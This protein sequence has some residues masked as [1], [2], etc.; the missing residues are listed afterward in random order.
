MTRKSTWFSVVL[1][2]G[3]LAVLLIALGAAREPAQADPDGEARVCPA[4]PPTCDFGTIQEAV[5]AAAPGD[6]IKVADGT[7]TDMHT[8]PIP[9]NYYAPPASGIITQI[10]YVTK[11]LTIRG[12]YAPGNWVTSDPDAYLTVLDAQGQGRAV[13]VADDVSVTLES[14]T[15][16]GGDALGLSGDV[17]GDAG[18]ALFARGPA[19]WQHLE[20]SVVRC[21]V[22]DNQADTGG[23]IYAGSADGITILNSE[24]ISN[25]STDWGGGLYM[26]SV[27]ES[28][29]GNNRIQNNSAARSGGGLVLNWVYDASLRGNRVV[30]NTAGTNGGGMRLSRSE[31]EMVNNIVALNAA[32]H[33]GDGV[34]VSGWANAPQELTMIHN[35][36]VQNDRGAGDSEAV[37]VNYR[38]EVT[39]TNTIIAS[40]TLGIGVTPASSN[41]VTADHTLFFGNTEDTSG[42]VITSTNEITG[43]DPD[44]VNPP[45][46]DF[47][48]HRDSPAV[49]AGIPVPAVTTDIDGHTRD[50]YPDIGADEVVVRKIH[51]PLIVR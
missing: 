22:V 38:T 44:F 40:H 42:A 24:I 3:S 45:A 36:I 33:A 26:V 19:P 17:G 20:L 37:Y 14:L 23:G 18:G 43:S 28:Y 34:Y 13:V 25:M 1:G 46:Y 16:T 39:L 31:I 9:V 48:L 6:V 32:D 12:G 27:G 21:A 5:D 29:M 30:S 41:T 4:G 10:V 47:H 2:L 15:L 11:S 49:D 7:Y 35:T 8:R 50:A 51:L